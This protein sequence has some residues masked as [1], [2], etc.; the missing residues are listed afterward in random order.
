[1]CTKNSINSGQHKRFAF[2]FYPSTDFLQAQDVYSYVELLYFEQTRTK[3][4]SSWIRIDL[5]LQETRCYY[6]KS[7]PALEIS[8]TDQ[9]E[10]LMVSNCRQPPVCTAVTSIKKA[11][12]FLYMGWKVMTVCKA[13]AEFGCKLFCTFVVF[14]QWHRFTQK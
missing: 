6:R 4:L 9:R 8:V 12:A 7:F 5:A 10:C 13:S 3:S 11:K 1:M 14:P 2:Q